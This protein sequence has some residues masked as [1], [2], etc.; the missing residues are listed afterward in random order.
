MDITTGLI[1]GLCLF[2][3]KNT[4]TLKYPRGRERLEL[5]GVILCSIIMGIANM[6]L[7]MQALSAILTGKVAPEV[8]LLIIGIM[9]AGSL[10]KAVFMVIC[11]KRGSA[12]SKV[13][14]MDM[15][16]DIA[17]TLVAITCATIG[18]RYWPY[19]DPIGAIVVCGLIAVS[20]FHNALEYVPILVGVRGERVLTSIVIGE[21]ECAYVTLVIEHDDRIRFIDHLMVYHTGIRATVELHI[22]LDENLPLKITHDICHPLEKKLLKLDFVERAFIHCD[23]DCDGD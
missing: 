15:R 14:A 2:L 5:L 16:N 21:M 8:N 19:A 7:I 1:L 3:V 13:L 17:T 23:Y 18:D 22:V 10:L 9:L 12:S 4:N 20:W 11:Y 6:F